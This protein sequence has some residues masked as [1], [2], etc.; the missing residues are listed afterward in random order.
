MTADVHSNWA[1]CKAF[2][3]L[4][5][6]ARIIAAAMLV[7][8]MKKISDQPRHKLSPV[9][10]RSGNDQEKK[11]Y[12]M[13]LSGQI[14]DQF[15]IDQH[16]LNS[17]LDGILSEQEKNDAVN[18]Q[19]LTTDGRFPCRSPGCNKSF[20][21]DGK[22]RRDHELTHDPPPV[23]PEKP[24]LSS[25]YPK[26]GSLSDLNDHDDIFNYNCSLLAQGLLFLNFL[27]STS[28]GDGDRSIRCWKFFLLHFK[29]DKSATKYAL[30]AL[31]LLLQVYSLLPPAEAHSLV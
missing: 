3:I 25:N 6:K 10:A 2:A 24:V 1:H 8:D 26:K 22:R 21:Y 9:A 28:E 4:E 11:H 27:D 20:K 7:L 30:E 29:E 31:Y 12:L 15:V 5:I 18:N 14:V 13:K 23:I 16:S 19:E 17:F